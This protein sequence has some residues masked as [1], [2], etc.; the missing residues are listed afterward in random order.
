MYIIGTEK[1]IRASIYLTISC[2]DYMVPVTH[3][4]WK[5]KFAIETIVNRRLTL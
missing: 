5:L 3:L 1:K 2:S 4:Q